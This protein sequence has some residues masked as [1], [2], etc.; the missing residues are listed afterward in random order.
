MFILH[1]GYEEGTLANSEDP[2]EMP[3]KASSPQGL[4]CLLKI[5]FKGRNILLCRNFDWQ[6]LKIQNGQYILIVSIYMG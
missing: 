2:D 5:I 4:Y 3:L 6:L 1:T